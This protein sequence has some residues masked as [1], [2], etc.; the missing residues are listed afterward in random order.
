MIN[1]DIFGKMD[2]NELG[3][4]RVPIEKGQVGDVKLSCMDA[5]KL[6]EKME[7]I[8]DVCAQKLSEDKQSRWKNC[9]ALYRLTMHKLKSW[10]VFSFEDV[11]DFQLTGLLTTSW[12]STSI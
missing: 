1:C 11:C 4:W 12:K 3:Q 7:L 6:I 10:K 9:A 8:V 5:N 2:F